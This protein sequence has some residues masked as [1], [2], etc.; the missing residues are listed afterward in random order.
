[1][2]PKFRNKLL[3]WLWAGICNSLVYEAEFWFKDWS[4]LF[5]EPLEHLQCQMSF[6]H[7]LLVLS[8][9]L[10]CKMTML[11]PNFSVS[12]PMVNAKNCNTNFFYSYGAYK[13]IKIY[14][15]GAHRWYRN[16]FPHGSEVHCQILALPI[17]EANGE[18][19][20]IVAMVAH[21]RCA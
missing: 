19:Y 8:W 11:M 10:Q 3:I 16:Q 14:F 13:C 12:T 6:W 21:W 9:A 18:Y 5:Q 15:Y 17:G 20:Y 1:M 7:C 2:V 4:S